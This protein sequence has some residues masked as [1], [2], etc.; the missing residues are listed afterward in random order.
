M[1][2]LEKAITTQEELDAIIGER[3]KRE[4]ESAAKRYEGWTSPDDLKKLTD[5]H[6]AEIKK[7]TDAA[8]ETQKQ[9]EEK[10]KALAESMRYKTDL[11][12]TRIVLAAGLKPDYADRLKGST[13]EEWEKDAKTIAK[14]FDA[15]RS[16]SPMGNPD[17]VVTKGDQATIAAK[18]FSEW[19]GSQFGGN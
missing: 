7:L 15:I 12:K 11:E 18:K 5:D 19:F 8:A 2:A 13:A 3:L 14:D 1:A 6:E 16:P 17:P 9:M 4:K 10:D